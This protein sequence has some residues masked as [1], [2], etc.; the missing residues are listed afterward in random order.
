MS[1]GTD[2]TTMGTGI[3]HVSS[4]DDVLALALAVVKPGGNAMLINEDNTGGDWV[5]VE[6]A[7][8][9]G[10]A[11]MV[12]V[13]P[14]L[15]VFD[16]DTPELVECG[17]K[18]RQWAE[19]DELPT[20]LVASGRDDHQHLYIR[21]EDRGRVLDQA[22][23]LGIPID[24]HRH[25]KGIRPP[26][27]PHRK[28]L[29]GALIAP[30]TVQEALG[31]L[32]PSERDG[33]KRRDLPMSLW[34]LI[35]NGDTEGRYDG[36]SPMALAI[37][38][39]LRRAGW[40]FSDYQRLMTDRRNAGGAK[41]HALEDRE[42]NENPHDFMVRTWEKA[43]DQLTTAEIVDEISN[44]QAIVEAAPWPGRTGKTDQAVMFALCLLGTT[45]G[46]TALTFGSRRI[47]EVA[48]M[49]DKTVRTALGRLVSAGW[50]ER[51]KASKIGDADTYQFGP[52][53]DKMTSLI[54]SPPIGDKCGSND[55]E[56]DRVLLHPLFRYGSGLG[57]STGQTWLGL[58]EVGPATVQEVSV[59]VGSSRRTVDRHLKVLEKH[60]L[61]VKSGTQWTASGDDRRLYE[62]AEEL[63]ALERSELQVERNERNREGF[64]TALRLKGARLAGPA[65][66]PADAGLVDWVELSEEEQAEILRELEDEEI[67]DWYEQQEL[68]RMLGL[69]SELGY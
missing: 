32:G 33:S 14:T 28:G 48:Q 69:P 19:A 10:R 18:L 44:V 43:A 62:L 61:A 41:V 50:L 63:G 26:L 36:R 68:Y 38:S 56:R 67:R 7:V 45:S 57:K 52:Q 49:E 27:A 34:S 47:A 40:N 39:G 55:Q 31:V 3:R 22:L 51:V 54:P 1:T 15:A 5:P 37:A 13:K 35:K 59:A 29:S 2:Q 53:V 6:E 17:W 60:G 21:S 4:T 30:E 65:E 16:L 66:A 25:N 20:L 58:Q 8:D 64:R 46:T 11:F 12:N 23:S 42:G 9:S 24:T